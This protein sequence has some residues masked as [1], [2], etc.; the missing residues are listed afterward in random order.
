MSDKYDVFNEH[1]LRAEIIEKWRPGG[2]H[3][4]VYDMILSKLST[5]KRALELVAKYDEFSDEE[6]ICP[7]GCDTPH[8]AKGALDEQSS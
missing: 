5:Y 7:Y 2:A 1:A 4:D 8:I 6:G 3:I